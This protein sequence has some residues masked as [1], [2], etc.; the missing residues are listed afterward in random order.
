MIRQMHARGELFSSALL[1]IDEENIQ[2]TALDL[3]LSEGFD[4]V[5]LMP[6]EET[7]LPLREGVRLR[8]GVHAIADTRS[9]FAK[10]G[11]EVAVLDEDGRPV[12]SGYD[13]HLQASI[14]SHAFGVKV[15]PGMSLAQMMFLHGWPKECIAN[16]ADYREMVPAYC[17]IDGKRVVMTL[18]LRDIGGDRGMIST[19]GYAAMQARD[20]IDLAGG[21]Q[22]HAGFFRHILGCDSY[23]FKKGRLYIT[24]TREA[25]QQTDAPML[26]YVMP[27]KGPKEGVVVNAA[28]LIHAGSHGQQAMEMLP[29]DDMTMHDGEPACYLELYRLL[30]VPDKRYSRENGNAT[31]TIRGPLFRN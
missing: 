6:G 20:V 7:V 11:V 30:D 5:T 9:R 8:P 21:T 27:R 4:P 25:L 29:D 28:S 12:K 15:S 18:G 1:G 23:D 14:R 31:D 2:P 24:R 16:P 22:T 26:A 17:R 19:V 10:V 3:T 13:G